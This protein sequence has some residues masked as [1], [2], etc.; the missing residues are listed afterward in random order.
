VQ[1]E[2]GAW[3]PETGEIR[4]LEARPGA[5]E[6]HHERI[7][8][9]GQ[10]QIYELEMADPAGHQTISLMRAGRPLKDNRLLPLGFVDPKDYPLAP[11]GVTDDPDFRPGAD[12]V[13]YAIPIE[14]A[15]GPWQVE[16]EALYQSIKPAHTQVFDARRSREEG[17]FRHAFVRDRRAPTVVESK[18]VQVP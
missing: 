13:T 4:S 9:P 3:N 12:T 5:I 10:T 17:L 16:I 15:A 14:P 8:A 2:S 11:V 7:T 6:P 18:M 1:F